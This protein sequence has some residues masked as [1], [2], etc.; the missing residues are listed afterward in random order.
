MTVRIAKQWRTSCLLLVWPAATVRAAQQLGY[1]VCWG[2]NHFGMTDVPADLGAIKDISAGWGHTCAVTESGEVVCWGCQ[3]GATR[4]S[5]DKGQCDVLTSGVV[6]KVATGQYHT[7]SVSSEGA[8]VDCW[9]GEGTHKV[10]THQPLEGLS[11]L[12]EV[13]AGGYMSCV[14]SAATKEVTCWGGDDGGS[15]DNSPTVATTMDLGYKHMCYIDNDGYVICEGRGKSGDTEVS[16]HGQSAVPSAVDQQFA[17]LVAAGGYHSCAV[18]ENGGI[19]CWGAEDNN[20]VTYDEGQKNVPAEAEDQPVQISAGF[21]HVCTLSRS[22]VVNCWGGNGFGQ[23]TVPSDLGPAI[24]VSAGNHHTCAM[25][26]ITSTST[27]TSVTVT[28]VTQTLTSITATGTTQTTTTTDTTLV[29]T[30]TSITTVT[31]VTE[32]V[33]TLTTLTATTST[34]TTSTRTTTPFTVTSTTHSTST[35]STS[36]V[37]TTSTSTETSTATS[38]TTATATSVSSTTTAS[39][40]TSVTATSL[41][42][43]TTATVTST[44][45]RTATTTVTSTDTTST[46]TTSTGTTVTDTTST[47]TGM[48]TTQAP[49]ETTASGVAATMT[50]MATTDSTSTAAPVPATSPSSAPPPDVDSPVTAATSTPAVAS[51]DGTA[52]AGSTVGA[53]V[54][55]AG[56]SAGTSASPQDG[57]VKGTAAAE[58]GV[59]SSVGPQATAPEGAST[60]AAATTTVT[61]TTT[62][63]VLEEVNRTVIGLLEGLRFSNSTTN[64]ISLPSGLKVAALRLNPLANAANASDQSDIEVDIDFNSPG[65]EVISVKIPYAAI[66]Q[67]QPSLVPG[68]EPALVASFLGKFRADR[69]SDGAA[70]ENAVLLNLRY[71]YSGD[72]IGVS[73]LLE[74]VSFTIPGVKFETQNG[75]RTQCFF[76]NETKELWTREGTGVAADNVQG[77]VLRCWT[78]HFSIFGAFLDGFLD[79]FVCAQ[80]SLLNAESVRNLGKGN[81]HQKKGTHLFWAIL[82]C[83]FLAFLVSVCLDIRRARTVAWTDEFFLIPLR[84]TPARESLVQRERAEE[85]AGRRVVMVMCGMWACF[86]TPCQSLR[87]SNAIRDALDDICSNWFENFSELRSFC[88]GLLGGLELSAC[89]AGRFFAISHKMM[90][91]MTVMTSRRMTSASLMVSNDLITFILE[92]EDLRKT[93]TQHTTRGTTSMPRME[94]HLSSLNFVGQTSRE[95]IWIQLHGEICQSL[96]KH[97]VVKRHSIWYFPI[98]FTQLF[99]SHTPFG[100]MWVLDIFMS[101]KMRAFLFAVELIG[102]LFLCSLFYQSSGGVRRAAGEV[103]APTG[104]PSP[105]EEECDAQQESAYVLGRLIA[106]AIGSVLFAG[107]PV[108]FLNSLHTREFKKFECAGT[109][110]WERQLRAWHIQDILIWVLGSIYMGGAVFFIHLFLANISEKD[111]EAFSEGGAIMLLQDF[112]ILPAAIAFLAP[113]MTWLLLAV[114]SALGST[115]RQSLLHSVRNHLYDN[116]N[117]LLPVMQV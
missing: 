79:T 32:T 51:T 53:V 54:A 59:S 97:V 113:G 115:D 67:L 60:V 49:G 101:C 44:T 2:D 75:K 63:G 80:F 95:E 17:V 92:D 47:D 40:T 88:E 20:G 38:T 33:T 39:S 52:A 4:G 29:T 74:P 98:S 1:A 85:S 112:V 91:N 116:S 83:L 111:H 57:G 77:E 103:A 16:A 65:E 69:N 9:G 50:S 25:V 8:H 105:E 7:C 64:E 45:T 23:S 93:I 10:I 89:Q 41:T 86:L 18:F 46:G 55:G 36:T 19:S 110:Q 114:T 3:T 73:G 109:P 70:L 72:E 78:T 28:T 82:G 84:S 96:Q 22:G 14:R 12:T 56:T 76:Y 24:K 58:I 104:P 61:T 71:L 99:F 21:F 31:T 102:S 106:I 94:R 48:A 37:S 34:R 100:N 11:N 87:D 66:L 62:L 5:V 27:T 117:M 42:A 108:S 13:H 6:E 30:T 68:D 15:L 26:L 107:L 90:T 35:A 81:W 43:T